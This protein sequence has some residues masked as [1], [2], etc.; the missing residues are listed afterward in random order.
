MK[1]GPQALLLSALIIACAVVYLIGNGSVSL[2]DRDEPRFAQ[3]SR[4]MLQ[5]GDWVVPRFLDKDR[6]AKPAMIYWLQASA[7]A[8]F[9]SN[10]FAARFPSAVAITLLL[11]V[12]SSVLWKPLGAE[13][14]VWT[15]FIFATSGLVITAAK[16]SITDATLLLWVTIAQICL[17]AMW[18]GNRSWSV[19]IILAVAIGLAGL[20]K[21]PVILGM[22]AMT[23][24]ML[25]LIAAIDRWLARRTANRLQGGFEVTN[26][27]T[28]F[29]PVPETVRVERSPLID[30]HS[31]ELEARV[32]AE[33][34]VAV[35]AKIVVAVL[36]VAAI[37]LPWVLMVNHRSSSFG[38]GV[39]KH[40]VW[41]RM[42][43]P[44]E[45]HY[46]PPGYYFLTIWVTYFPWS[47]ML[48][49]AIG[50]GI[51]RRANPRA[52]FA[53]AAILG[54]WIMLECVK[55]KLPHY[56][57]P[58]FPPLAFLTADALVRVIHGEIKD[59]KSNVF[60]S[61]VG[62]WAI[63]VAAAA[64][65]PW[66]VARVP[67]ISLP[68]T[69]MKIVSGYGVL[70]AVTVFICFAA[71]RV[72]SAAVVMGFGT[73]GLV[74]LLYGLY[75]PNA[76]FLR[77]SPRVAKI[78]IDHGVTHPH[79][80]IMMDYMEPSLAF[81][82]GGTMREAGEL[83]FTLKFEPRFTPW[84]VVTKTIW[85][86]APQELRDHFDVVGDVYGLAYADRGK[87]V[88]VMVIHHR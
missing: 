63:L 21:G 41:D 1:N 40:E 66:I 10:E 35:T 61:I 68:W 38:A 34:P 20:T 59:L 14:T 76:D 55:T 47:L 51:H 64:F 67:G 78:L 36:I 39:L 28:G 27:D 9:G 3:T 15:V 49:L 46:G 60:V 37:V 22:Q 62:I 88:H 26:H 65:G 50:L 44:L 29:R 23:L 86:K 81:A 32:A 2:W 8:V 33:D 85:D 74:A 72:A 4:Q 43:T 42:M 16:L 52:R 80:V 7:M 30:Y 57:L 54:P 82:Q 70:F 56:F 48:P 84:L 58:V 75:L 73:L 19:V 13:R 11:I 17:Y 87:W 71:R 83:G 12:L 18:R 45:Q 53:L 31:H 24:I 5:S 79:Q 69:A 25:W 77:V 6:T